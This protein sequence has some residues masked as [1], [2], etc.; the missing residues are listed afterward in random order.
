MCEIEN[1]AEIEGFM[2]AL[3]KTEEWN[4]C[5]TLLNQ[6]FCISRDYITQVNESGTKT[7]MAI[8][9]L[10]AL[11][12]RKYTKM[13]EVSDCLNNCL[14]KQIFLYLMRYL[15]NI[16]KKR[17][18]WSTGYSESISTHSTSN[19]LMVKKN[20]YSHMF[21]KTAKQMYKTVKKVLKQQTGYHC[22]SIKSQ[23][24]T[25]KEISDMTDKIDASMRENEN[26]DL[27]CMSNNMKCVYYDRLVMDTLNLIECL[28][29]N[30]GERMLL[31]YANT[32]FQNALFELAKLYI[33]TNGTEH[34]HTQELMTII[35]QY[36][37]AFQ[38][39]HSNHPF[40]LNLYRSV[41]DT[42][43][44]L[45]Q[46]CVH[47]GR[48]GLLQSIVISDKAPLFTPLQSQTSSTSSCND[49]ACHRATFPAS[50][51]DAVAGA[52]TEADLITF[53]FPNDPMEA[54]PVFTPDGVDTCTGYP[55]QAPPPIPS[56]PQQ[57]DQTI[58]VPSWLTDT[59]T[60]D[61]SDMQ[62]PPIP[63]YPLQQQRPFNP[64]IHQQPQAPKQ[65]FY[66]TPY[67]NTQCNTMHTPQQFSYFG[68]AD[69]TC[70]TP[71]QYNETSI[72]VRGH[73]F[74]PFPQLQ[75]EQGSISHH[76]Q[77]PPP[78]R[79]PVPNL[80]VRHNN[81][82]STCRSIP[83]YTDHLD[84]KKKTVTTAASGSTNTTRLLSKTYQTK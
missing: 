31:A 4:K 18:Y 38:E 50:E 23:S 48:G 21:P 2:P 65:V 37:H 24:S 32:E 20:K 52:E 51:S 22:E 14:S 83:L 61:R 67:G 47:S 10:S 44:R 5:K 84:W 27:A 30:C 73:P 11:E 1:T 13:F 33:V 12:E 79:Q 58:S 56:Q 7:K 3:A 35:K 81:N 69:M 49:E 59:P 34:S 60:H 43:S 76:F 71:E 55:T 54:V 29:H 9:K 16:L 26:N 68:A 42:Y 45:E 19:S 75:P 78:Y 28:M 46:F 64:H 62:P 6:Y 36:K 70:P 74:A 53:E 39:E 25:A 82:Q 77:H 66:N 17:I 57:V 40:T 72:A 41:L 8:R 15:Q 80:I 63:V